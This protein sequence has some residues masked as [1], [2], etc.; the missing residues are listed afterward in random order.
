MGTPRRDPSRTVRIPLPTFGF[1]LDARPRSYTDFPDPVSALRNGVAGQHR[2]EMIGDLLSGADPLM[3]A[4]AGPLE[5]E[6]LE[7]RASEGFVRTLTGVYGPSWLGGEYLPTRSPGEVELARIALASVTGDVLALRGRWSGGRYHYRIVDEYDAHFTLCRKSSRHPLTLGQVVE[8][9][10]TA[11]GDVDTGGRGLVRCWWDQQRNS[12]YEA[13]E[14]TD[15]AWV[16]SDLYPDLGPWYA[17]YAEA[18]RREVR[19]PGEVS[20]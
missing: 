4:L 9:L 6:I 3:G 2:R 10:E 12:G 13:E 5:E 11:D 7:E 8:I 16:E 20:R 17:A 1:D 15:F 19:D 18:W 14:C